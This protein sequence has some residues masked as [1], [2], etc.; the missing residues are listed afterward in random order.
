[1]RLVTWIS[2]TAGPIGRTMGTLA[3]ALQERIPYWSVEIQWA[4]LKYQM[5]A[6]ERHRK[7]VAADAE[8]RRRLRGGC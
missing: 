8:I 4:Y 1:M 6:P 5:Q 3:A 2:L 7:A